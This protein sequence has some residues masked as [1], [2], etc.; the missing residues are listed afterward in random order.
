MCSDCKY[1]L[2]EAIYGGRL[3]CRLRILLHAKLKC[4]NVAFN[5]NQ[6]GQKS[7]VRNSECGLGDMFHPDVSGRDHMGSYTSH[8]AQVIVIEGL[9]KHLLGGCKIN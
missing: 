6:R 7:E 9:T 3:V 8:K 5:H 4:Y 2:H 1:G